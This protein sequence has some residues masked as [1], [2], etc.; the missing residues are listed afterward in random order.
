M[1]ISQ[2]AMFN[3]WCM[4]C[5]GSQEEGCGGELRQRRDGSIVIL[6]TLPDYCILLG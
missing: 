4:W 6:T 5:S 2:N 3:A 1:M